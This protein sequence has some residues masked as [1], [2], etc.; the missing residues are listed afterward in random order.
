MTNYVHGQQSASGIVNVEIQTAAYKVSTRDFGKTLRMNQASPMTFLL[1]PTFNSTDGARVIFMKL[2]A[3]RLTVKAAGTDTIRNSSN[4]GMIYC[5]PP[6]ETYAS[7]S[8]EYVFAVS[9]WVVNGVQGTWI[10][11]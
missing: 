8:L 9:K 7:L 4:G 2:G 6:D 3:G 1:P 10:T 11:K 5:D